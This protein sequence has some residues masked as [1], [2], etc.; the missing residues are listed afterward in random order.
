MDFQF[1]IPHN[2]GDLLD[3]DGNKYYV[4]QVYEARD[5]PEM[6]KGIVG[7]FIFLNCGLYINNILL[8]RS[9]SSRSKCLHEQRL[10][11]IRSFRYILFAHRK[12]QPTV[13]RLANARP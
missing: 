12:R 6:L 13:D 9:L 11:H 7:G 5:L 2:S 10:L 1:V 4:K 8:G 3:S